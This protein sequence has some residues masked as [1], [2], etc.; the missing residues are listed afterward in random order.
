[1]VVGVKTECNAGR[2]VFV[3]DR[4][5]F[6]VEVEAG[7]RGRE[8]HT[9]VVVALEIDEEGGP[10]VVFEFATFA[11]EALGGVEP[12]GEVDEEGQTIGYGAAG[13]DLGDEEVGVEDVGGGGGGGAVVHGCRKA[14][15]EVVDEDVV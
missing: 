4:G 2:L 9:G 5:A 13:G 3:S 6:A 12:F 15:G 1:L 7:V 8:W 14:A 11:D 10:E